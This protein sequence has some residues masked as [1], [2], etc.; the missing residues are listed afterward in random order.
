[1]QATLE[2]TEQHW[3][4]IEKVI[5]F[6]DPYHIWGE[7]ET[8]HLGCRYRV[9]RQKMKNGSVLTTHTAEMEQ[10]LQNLVQ[11]FETKHGIKVKP[12]TTPYLP[13]AEAKKVEE[14]GGKHLYGVDAASPIMAGLYS[15]R[16][17]RPDLNVSTLRLA[18]RTTKWTVVDDAR[19]LRYLGY[20]KLTAGARLQSQLSTDDLETAVLR[21]WPDADLAGDAS[22][23]THS[24]GG[25]WIELASVDGAR[26]FALHW[27]YGKQGF[28]AGHTQE[29]EVAAMYDA[30]RNDGLPIA[31]LLEFLLERPIAVE[32]RGQRCCDRCCTKWL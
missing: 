28:T 31:S 12:V 7:K 15:A 27:N 5:D 2:K 10:Y 24:S 25:S 11:K 1:L 29:A 21:I 26:S 23:D 18:R 19:L 32:P 16:S 13:S 6:K 30:L 4:K 20:I 8:P 22:E 14:K 3:S 9:K 17:A